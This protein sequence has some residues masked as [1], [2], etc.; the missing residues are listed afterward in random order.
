M[1]L[2][3]KIGK[4]F[5]VTCELGGT[6]GTD[7]EKSIEDAGQLKRADAINLIDCAMARL[8]INTFSLAHIIQ[9]KFDVCCVPHLTRR[10][11][12]ILGLQSDL[13]GAHAL[14]VRYVLATTG[15]PP[16]HGPYKESKGVFNINT[17]RLIQLISD[18]NKGLDY[19][20]E[21]IKGNTDFFVSATATPAA[22]NLDK[23]FELVEKKVS[24]G[25]NFLQTQPVYDA[26]QARMF[27]DK[28]KPLN[29]PVL[30][31]VM[32]LK[33]VKMA[34]FMND[35]VPGIE[36]PEHVI[37]KFEQQGSGIPVSNEFIDEIY[38]IADG[39]HI[40]AMGN[41]KNMN[42]ILDHIEN[43]N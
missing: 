22:K 43:K 3:D 26:D 11:R 4:K 6:D 42:G 30:I 38:D 16:N 23:E 7:I 37:E 8:R 36:V 17:T 31:G 41:V 12:S 20:G 27:I 34:Q 18:L 32:P 40:L 14:G 39:I 15:D 19:N 5:V 21:E 13:L 24:A 10:D 1:S 28:M 25:A 9:D 2:K 33:S 29:I 35:K